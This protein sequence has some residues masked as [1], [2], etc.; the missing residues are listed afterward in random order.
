[1]PQHIRVST[2][3]LA[4]MQGFLDALESILATGVRVD[5]E[6]PTQLAVNSV[7]PNPFNARCRIKLSIPSQEPVNLVLYDIAGRKVRSLVNGALV[8]GMH[9]ITWDGNNSSG[10]GCT[11]GVYI[12]RVYTGIAQSTGQLILIH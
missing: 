11:N 6:V 10:T 8:A 3:L 2:G 1:M 12:Y 5:T 4:E 7:H 9:E